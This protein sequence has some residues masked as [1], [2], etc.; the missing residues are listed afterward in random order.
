MFVG[1]LAVVG[2]DQ[3]THALGECLVRQSPALKKW[4]STEIL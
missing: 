4:T 2:G 1:N 3:T